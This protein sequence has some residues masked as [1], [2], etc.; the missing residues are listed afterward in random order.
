MSKQ[1]PWRDDRS[2]RPAQLT[3][4]VLVALQTYWTVSLRDVRVRYPN[5]Q[6]ERSSGLCGQGDGEGCDA[7]VDTGEPYLS[8]AGCTVVLVR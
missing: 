5:E 8:A 3:H 7:I 1:V 4:T 6:R 2:A